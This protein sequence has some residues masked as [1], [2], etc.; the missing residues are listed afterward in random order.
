[1]EPRHLSDTSQLTSLRFLA[2]M[3]VV[4]FHTADQ[5]FTGARDLSTMHGR[6]LDMGFTAV[7][8]FFV[9]SGFVLTIAYRNRLFS[10]R[11]FY[12][13]RIAR[14]YPLFI[15]TLLLDTPDYFANLLGHAALPE[16]LSKTSIRLVG[17]A[18]LI[19]A[20]IPRLRGMDGPNWSLS[21][22]A[23]L[24]LMFPF[25]LARLKPS[26]A[27]FLAFAA[28]AVYCASILS[29]S[30][31]LSTGISLSVIRFNPILHVPSFV[32]GII[33]AL[34]LMRFPRIANHGRL[35]IA[36]AALCLLA[37]IVF[38]RYIPMPLLNDGLLAPVYAT[39]VVAVT[40]AS[41]LVDATLCNKWMVLCGDA[42]YGMYL[43]HIPIWHIAIRC[44]IARHPELYSVYLLLVVAAGIFSLRFVETPARRHLQSFLSSVNRPASREV[45]KAIH[46]SQPA[47][48]VSASTE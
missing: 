16:A 4:C 44:G 45:A 3:Y 18:A 27:R 34:L 48:T 19:Q 23:F 41:S 36:A 40:K 5:L 31:L 42:S 21:V 35:L 11:Q 46:D 25:V 9:L 7:S 10:I 26:S 2:A 28:V 33:S 43:L 38:Y 32:I 20:W 17:N 13:A 1:M 12:I 6:L 14:I 37:T 15:F 24:Y 22:E 47:F 39:I 30:G 8:F 29:V